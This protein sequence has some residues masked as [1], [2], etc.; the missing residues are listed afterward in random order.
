MMTRAVD[1]VAQRR[2]DPDPY[3]D[4]IPICGA[5]HCY[6]VTYSRIVVGG[7]VLDSTDSAFALEALTLAER[8]DRHDPEANEIRR[9]AGAAALSIRNAHARAN[10][11]SLVDGWSALREGG[12]VIE[13]TEEGVLIKPADELRLTCYILLVRC[14]STGRVYSL[15][16]PSD[17]RTVAS[18]R[19][20]VMHGLKPDV[21][22]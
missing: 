21:E 9:R 5:L 8:A 15:L 18:A 16:V 14:P 12:K 4:I 11:L 17:M 10:V 7:V 22:T 13:E 1:L 20:W 3:H 19:S 2:G 6:S